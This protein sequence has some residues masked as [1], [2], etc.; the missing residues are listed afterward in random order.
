MQLR[1][2]VTVACKAHN[3]DDQVQ[4]LAPQQVD[5]KLKLYKTMLLG[6]WFCICYDY[7]PGFS[8]GLY[9]I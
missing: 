5:I 7:H 6:A 9:F 8:W 1:G 4:F 3:L 2:G